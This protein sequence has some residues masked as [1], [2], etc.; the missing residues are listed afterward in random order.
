MPTNRLYDTWKTRILELRPGQRITQIRA[1]VWLIVGI[2]QSRSVCLSKIACKVPGEAKLLSTIRRLSRLLDNPAIRVREWYEP[3][4]RHWLEAQQ[5]WIGEVRLIVD[6]TKV[7][8]GHQLLIVALAYRKRAIPIAWT[9]VRTARGHS[10]AGKQLALLAYVHKLLPKNAAVILV[11]DT[12]FGSVEV[13]KQL[14]HWRWFYVLRQKSDT[15]VWLN[16]LNE[17]RT[18]G[19]FVSEAGNSVWLG[20]GY[21]TSKAIYPTNL[22]VHW[23]VG[24]DQPWCLATNLPDFKMALKVY[25]RRMWIEEMFGDFKKHGFDLENS[26]LR[27]FL[28]LSRLTL[29]VAL[30]YVWLVSVGGRTIRDG[31]RHL[32]DR[33]DRR[34]LSIFQIGLRMIERSVTNALLFR[35]PL[36]SYLS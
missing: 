22:L 4:A 31:L 3:I 35:I 33:K 2:Y 20:S 8:F 27:H 29:A 9:W 10:S 21:L 30:L 23:K 24:E 19:S 36:F 25:S 32:V 26:M 15:C 17:W 14:D 34:D 5:R 18:F 13:L 6:G 7:S 16:P 28:R 11:G 12:E 1:F